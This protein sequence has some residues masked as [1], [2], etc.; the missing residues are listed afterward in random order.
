MV[1]IPRAATVRAML[2]D[3]RI[4]TTSSKRCREI[5]PLTGTLTAWRPLAKAQV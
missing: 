1:G 3:C 2:T 4:R 5:H